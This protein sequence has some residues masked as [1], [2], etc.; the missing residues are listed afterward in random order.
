MVTGVNKNRA[1]HPTSCNLV[2]TNEVL[3]PRKLT[4][5][6]KNHPSLM[7]GVPLPNPSSWNSIDGV[8]GSVPTSHARWKISSSSCQVKVS[9]LKIWDEWNQKTPL[10]LQVCFIIP[11]FKSPFS[12]SISTLEGICIYMKKIYVSVFTYRIAYI[13]YVERP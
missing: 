7:C 13:R 5:A 2:Q 10:F 3:H 4:W 12:G 8:F 11:F 9:S 1:C 6:P